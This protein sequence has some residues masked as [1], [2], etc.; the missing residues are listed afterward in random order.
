MSPEGSMFFQRNPSFL[1]KKKA[2]GFP[3]PSTVFLQP[4]FSMVPVFLFDQ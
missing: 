3:L 4:P 1:K 2:L